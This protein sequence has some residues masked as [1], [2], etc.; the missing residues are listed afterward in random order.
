MKER[1]AGLIIKIRGFACFT[2]ILAMFGCRVSLFELRSPMQ[3]NAQ[4]ILESG[5]FFSS[6]EDCEDA[7]VEY[8]GLCER[9][10]MKLTCRVQDFQENMLRRTWCEKVSFWKFF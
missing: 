9:T 2:A 3:T 1:L 4:E 8:V 10:G 6:R 5:R 7:K